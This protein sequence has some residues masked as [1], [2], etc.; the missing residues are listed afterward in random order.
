MEGAQPER[1]S[2]ASWIISDPED[3]QVPGKPPGTKEPRCYITCP[4]CKSKID[5][6][7][8]SARSNRPFHCKQHISSGHCTSAASEGSAIVA[9]KHSSS[10]AYVQ[11]A[12]VHEGCRKEIDDLKQSLADTNSRLDEVVARTSVYD[13]ALQAV[14]PALELPLVN[15]RA[16]AQIRLALPAPAP[17]SSMVLVASS[18]SSEFE[19]NLE[20]RYDRLKRDHETAMCQLKS[21]KE[22]NK[23]LKSGDELRTQV[24]LVR[25]YSKTVQCDNIFHENMH[26]ELIKL[27]DEKTDVSKVL[28]RVLLLR[29]KHKKEVEALR[30]VR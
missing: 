11:K 22:E 20:W 2:W 4:D 6:A 9:V 12:K 23:R 21:V 16:E 25:R 29:S 27:T 17:L 19:G 26:N 1:R 24:Q 8:A 5:V 3:R 13:R 18:S 30:E 14:M 7:A 10:R 28:E 15:E